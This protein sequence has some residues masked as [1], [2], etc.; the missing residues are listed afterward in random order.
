MVHYLL[1]HES[2]YESI[3]GV[4]DL[5]RCLQFGIQGLSSEIFYLLVD[6]FESKIDE[7]LAKYTHSIW[8]IKFSDDDTFVQAGFTE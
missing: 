1:S 4:Y 7:V 2:V 8:D 6:V 5:Y 3:Q